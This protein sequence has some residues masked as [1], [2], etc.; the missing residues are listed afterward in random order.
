MIRQESFLAAAKEIIKWSETK[1]ITK[2]GLVGEEDSGKTSL[3]EALSHIIHK[4]S[5]LEWVVRKFYERELMDFETTLKSLTPANHILIFDDVSFLS[6]K[7]GKKSIDQVKESVTK[8]RHLPGGKDVKII[9][10]YNYHYTKGLD[11]YLRQAHFRFFTTIGSEEEDNMEDIVGQKNLWL[12]KFFTRALQQGVIKDYFPSPARIKNN[13]KKFFYKYRD[14]FIPILFWN[15]STL[16]MIIS[17]LR[18]WLQPICSVCS[19]ATGEAGTVDVAQFCTEFE[20]AYPKW[21]ITII[22]QFLKERGV[23]CYSKN[24]VSGRRFLDRA[25][26]T[27]QFNL[28]D[29]AA[30]LGLTQTVTRLRKKPGDFTSLK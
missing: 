1:D 7:H 3:A 9:L 28:D 10:I 27:K 13:K 19:D 11:K 6:G 30:H 21:S 24:V 14:P 2:V 26:E 23:N 15:N 5:K 20:K 22:K 16:R 18:Q 25:L 4:E 8:I 17:P 12:I 29:L